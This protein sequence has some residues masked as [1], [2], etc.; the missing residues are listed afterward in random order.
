M[1][2]SSA[3]IHA[4]PGDVAV[5][6]AG[7]ALLAGVEV[8][9][10]SPEGKMIVTIETEDDGSNA[11]GDYKGFEYA[12]GL[13]WRHIWNHSGYSNTSISVLGTRLD[14]IFYETKSDSLLV[15]ETTD[16]RA[17][18]IRNINVFQ[19]GKTDYIEFGFDTKYFFNKYDVYYGP[20]TNALGDNVP[21][22]IVNNEANA[23]KAG[24]HAGITLSPLNALTTTLG[25]RYD[26][27]DYNKHSHLSPRFSFLLRISD[28]LTINGATGIYY[29]NLPLNILA[30]KES[31]K[32]LK[33][34]VSNHFILGMGYLLTENTKFSLEGYYKNYE[35]FPI[36][37]DQPQFF[38]ADAVSFYGFFGNYE[39]LADVG[40]ARAY[41]LEAILQKKLVKGFY[42]LLSLS[43][44][45]SEYK[46]LDN[47]WRDRMFDNRLIFGAEGGFKPNNRW[48][49]SA[50]WI[51]AGGVPYTPLDITAS[52][53]LNRSVL[54]GNR[55]NS[56]R[57][58]D[59]HSMNIRVDKRFL[60]SK[61]NLILYF[62]IWN[63]YNRK[64]VSG[65]Y[66]NEI[67]QNQDVRYQ[68]STLPVFGLE[69]EF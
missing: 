36:D 69:Y 18:Q 27:F 57:I 68:W 56:K 32:E 30:Q 52:Q 42:G 28:R 19:L 40:K 7:L 34:I 16:D 49:F 67:E 59:Y 4:R 35:N 9:A 3:I 66:W 46:S 13:N 31:N 33:D 14:D 54:D 41:G 39:R 11:Y 5:V 37:P 38:A 48:E 45:K 26:Y 12:S 62:S 55:V 1:H 58:P 61:S 51:F 65:Y 60:F 43:Y 44:S 25:L 50:R 20:Y 6:Q 24:L 10:I 15:D 64:N 53:L 17:V 63:L 23:L 8:H 21:A 47:I 2:I 22:L 29:Q